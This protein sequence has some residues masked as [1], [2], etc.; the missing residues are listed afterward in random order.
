MLTTGI[1]IITPFILLGINWWNTRQGKRK[2]DERKIYE[3]IKA[4]ELKED[5]ERKARN[6]KDMTEKI[7]EEVKNRAEEVAK[8]LEE[9]TANI[10]QKS[11]EYTEKTN[12]DIIARIEVIDTKVMSMLSDLRKRAELTN[13]NVA[14]LRNDIADLQDQMEDLFEDRGKSDSEV[15]DLQAQR[16]QKRKR[17]QRR[18]QID[19][20]RIAQS[21]RSLNPT[22]SGDR[23]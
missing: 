19:S 21:E 11:K 9:S 2:E 17:R 3:T 5:D 4:K 23:W 6:L 15:R 22:A 12:R 7:A 1:I 18:R 13:G 16:D 14:T 8:E 20:D 10:L